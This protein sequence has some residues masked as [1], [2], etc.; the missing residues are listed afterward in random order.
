MPPGSRMKM[1]AATVASPPCRAISSRVDRVIDD[2]HPPPDQNTPERVRDAVSD[3]AGCSRRGSLG[4]DERERQAAGDPLPEQGAADERPADD[5]DGVSTN[6]V[7]EIARNSGE[8]LLINEEVV[9]VEPGVAVVAGLIGEVA[10][11]TEG[12]Q[13]DAV[14]S[15]MVQRSTSSPGLNRPP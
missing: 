6:P 7:R 2:G 12:I 3:A 5:I 11:P 10:G 9:E 8:P 1:E 14:V 13:M 15:H 4:V